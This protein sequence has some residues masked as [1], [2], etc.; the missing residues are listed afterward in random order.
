MLALVTGGGGF[1]G[2]ALVRRLLAAGYRV[3][4]F[5]RGSY[6]DLAALGVEQFQG[7]LA[8]PASL[9]RACAGCGIVFHVAARAGLAG[10][11]WDYYRA[12]VLGTRH[13]VSACRDHGI[14]RLVYTSSPSAVFTGRDMAGA[15]ESVPYPRHHEAHY[16]RSKALAERH[17]LAANGP[18]LATVALRPHLIWGPGDNH[19]VPRILAR[20]RAGR[21][22]RV[23]RDNQLV[24]ST[25]VDNA[26]DAHVLAAERLSFGSPVAGRAYFISNGEPLP[27][28]DLVNRILAAA[29]L[30]PVRRAVPP[31]LAWLAGALCE[32]AWGI[33][34]PRHEP[35]MTRFL[36]RELAT[37]HWFDLSAAR[38]D[39]GYAPRVTID[40][41]L[42]RLA[43]W[44]A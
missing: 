18:D 23:G 22:R 9:D 42:A 30:G 19:L 17:V 13:V 12:N 14:A 6:P 8:D 35:P 27:L 33:F 3:R 7:D 2:S 21:L 1:L 24:D 41:G 16:P 4:T 39:L 5:S 40:E 29:G 25:Y 44:L 43:R 20:A 11:W 26:A 31:R 10:R 37:A 36:A 38:G 34:W 15:D 28:W 32:L